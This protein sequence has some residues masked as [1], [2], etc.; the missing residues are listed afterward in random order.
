[1]QNL[2]QELGHTLRITI[3]SDS[4]AAKDNLESPGPKKL[5]HME[6]K[7]MFLRDLVMSGVVCITKIAGKQ[8]RADG[9][10]KALLPTDFVKCLELA[11]L[12]R[13]GRSQ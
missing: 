9:L 5:K 12:E 7:N 8:N 1:M 4:K 2:L 11:D 3:Y 13:I 6:L 10:T